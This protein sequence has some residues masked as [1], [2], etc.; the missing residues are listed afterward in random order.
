MLPRCANYLTQY[1]LGLKSMKIELTDNLK[2]ANDFSDE[3][4]SL[5]WTKGIACIFEVFQLH[6]HL[7]ENSF[8]KVKVYFLH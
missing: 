7:L 2:N 1:S 5:F 4:W 6:N 3:K 8:R